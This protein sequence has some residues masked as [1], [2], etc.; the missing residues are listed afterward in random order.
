MPGRRDRERFGLFP[1]VS[2]Q[3][4]PSTSILTHD[5]IPFTPLTEQ[6]WQ[7]VIT[8]SNTGAELSSYRITND[9]KE[10]VT[11]KLADRQEVSITFEPNDIETDGDGLPRL[12]LSGKARGVAKNSSNADTKVKRTA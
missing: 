1:P 11:I 6:E 5:D 8:A 3:S 12:P 4:T 7:E 10:E 9:H 2:R